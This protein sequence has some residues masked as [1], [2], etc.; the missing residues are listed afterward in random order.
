MFQTVSK[1]A[2]GI[3]IAGDFNHWVPEPLVR[4]DEEGLW[5]KI[6]PITQGS[7]RYKFIIDGEWQMDPY[8]P[9]QKE[10]A[11]GTYDSYLEIR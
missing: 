5:Q 3:E 1:T 11:F 6:V 7:F 8:Q 10:N 2:H 4:R 9:M